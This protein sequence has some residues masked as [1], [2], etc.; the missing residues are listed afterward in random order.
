MLDAD[1]MVAG[2]VHI[3]YNLFYEIIIKKISI[4]LITL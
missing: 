1:R 2:L 3:D 4:K